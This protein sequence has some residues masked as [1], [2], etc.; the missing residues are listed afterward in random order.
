MTLYNL[1]TEK[2]K[3]AGPEFDFID[4]E[5]MAGEIFT[6]TGYRVEAEQLEIFHR[7][8][9]ERRRPSNRR[10]RGGACKTANLFI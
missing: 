3:E 10:K 8:Y 5:R 4:F 2:I 7:L 1:V 6:K 9:Y